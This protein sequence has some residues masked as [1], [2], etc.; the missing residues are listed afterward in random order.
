MAASQLVVPTEQI[1]TFF[2]TLDKNA[3][4]VEFAN[5]V[6]DG[7]TRALGE[8]TIFHVVR[9]AGMLAGS[10]YDDVTTNY[11]RIANKFTDFSVARELNGHFFTEVYGLTVQHDTVEFLIKHHGLSREE[12]IELVQSRHVGASALALESLED[13]THT[14]VEGLTSNETYLTPYGEGIVFSK[15]PYSKPVKKVDLDDNTLGGTFPIPI[16]QEKPD[17]AQK[18]ELQFILRQMIELEEPTHDHLKRLQSISVMRLMLQYQHTYARDEYGRVD[19]MRFTKVL[20]VD[21][22]SDFEKSIKQ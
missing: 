14:P 9:A 4:H 1:V 2:E 8:P 18:S 7:D 22:I 6:L 5:E 20:G 13:L 21:T 3:P 16:L 19:W 11:P 10:G 15:N 17:K 12:A